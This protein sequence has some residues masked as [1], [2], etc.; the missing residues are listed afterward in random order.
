MEAVAAA[1]V[2]A[3]RLLN[4]PRRFVSVPVAL[5]G[6]Y[7]TPLLLPLSEDVRRTPVPWS[8]LRDR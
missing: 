3:S 4:R 2:D 1:F 5:R 6:L 7:F 8:H